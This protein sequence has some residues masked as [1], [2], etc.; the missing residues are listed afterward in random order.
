MKRKT[1]ILIA[2]IALALT[3][4]DPKQYAMSTAAVS[5][6]LV[7]LDQRYTA[8]QLLIDGNMRK[9]TKRDQARLRKIGANIDDLRHTAHALITDSGGVAHA[10]VS[11]DKIRTLF[12]IARSTY[13]E[14]KSIIHKR[15]NKF[16]VED[17]ITLHEFDTI[18]VRLNDNLQKVLT[19]PDGTDITPQ[20]S[21]ALSIASTAAKLLIPL[22]L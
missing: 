3:A 1:L 16:T 19:A 13:G 14:A 4:C 10:L 2:L 22:L 18:A 5:A 15:I 12:A 21:D 20:I 7:Q 8:V 9:F 17:Q 6:S 11:A